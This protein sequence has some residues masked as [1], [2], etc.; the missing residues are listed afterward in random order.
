MPLGKPDV[1]SRLRHSYEK[2]SSFARSLNNDSEELA[3]IGAAMDAAIKKLNLGVEAWSTIATGSD[4][5]QPF[6]SYEDRLGYAKI[7][8][9]W[10]L[11]IRE[12]ECDASDGEEK[13]VH[14]WLFAEAPRE[15]R[16][17]AVDRLPELIEALNETVS[18]LHNRM[19]KKIADAR[20]ILDALNQRDGTTEPVE[21]K[22]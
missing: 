5:N 8:G 3:K 22:K 2:L 13:V 4:E 1:L 14:E 20:S 11:A 16:I 9:K 6:I 12:V 19:S 15:M 7:D 18:A 17:L 21:G 10:G